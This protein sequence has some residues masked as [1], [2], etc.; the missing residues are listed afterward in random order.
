MRVVFVNLH[1][2]AFL[3][4]TLNKFLF[5]RSAAVKHRYFLDYLLSRDD[6]EVCNYINDY[7]FSLYYKENGF[8]KF[9]AKLFS[10]IENRY[11]LWKNGI[12]LKLVKVIS[13]AQ[14]TQDDIVITYLNES[15]TLYRINDINAFK[16][17]S[18]LHFL[19]EARFSEMAQKAGI[20][21]I[22]DESD[23]NKYSEAFRLRF[24]WYNKPV[25][26][27]PFVFAPRF[28]KNKEMSDRENRAFSTG[29]IINL[30]R[31]EFTS[32]YG[33]PCNQPTR[34]QIF[35][36]AKELEPLVACYNKY[37]LEDDKLKQVKAS[38]FIFVK[39]YKIYY[40][41]SHTGRQKKYFSFDMVECFNN[42]KMFICGEEVV[43]IP[44]IGF[45]E[46]MACGGAYIGQT[47]GYY[48]DYG[49]K[50]GVHYIGYDGS[51]EDLK[52]KITYYQQPEHQDELER[53]ANAGYEF[54]NKHFRGEAVA[55]DLLNKLLEAQKEWKKSK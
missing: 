7:G 3:V 34:R 23:L 12:N 21:R 13:K 27:H 30:N 14:I 16:V 25:I 22:F 36:N 4:K 41:M 47:I 44:G 31:E 50:A 53:I 51:L 26:V 5:K 24:K 8:V 33:D 40:N 48:E 20:D 19:G 6:I 52:A 54:A 35:D 9:L 18:A 1:C 11:I 10:R 28:K 55:K 49:M 2:N 32:V 43:G 15:H 38:D 46:G 29:T 37:Y 17:A 39:W 42:F 45:V